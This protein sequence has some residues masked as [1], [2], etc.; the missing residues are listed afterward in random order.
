MSKTS[1][2]K[3]TRL[4][5]EYRRAK[6]ST[7]AADRLLSGAEQRAKAAHE[8]LRKTSEAVKQELRAAKLRDIV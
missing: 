3:L 8:N 1:D 5:E 7:Q 6:K 2:G 4:Y